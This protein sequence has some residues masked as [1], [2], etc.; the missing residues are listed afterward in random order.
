[1][2]QTVFLDQIM[3][4]EKAAMSEII[5]NTYTQ[6]LKREERSQQLRIYWLHHVKAYK[7]SELTQ[8]EFCTT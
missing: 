6:V 4:K 5:P 3:M 8:K 2:V 1:M 7:Q